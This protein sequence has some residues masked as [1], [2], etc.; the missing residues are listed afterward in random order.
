MGRYHFS[1]HQFYILIL[2]G[3]FSSMSYSQDSYKESPDAKNTVNKNTASH[4][5][6]N[7]VSEE[8]DQKVDSII[9]NGI[10]NHE[11]LRVLYLRQYSTGSLEC[12]L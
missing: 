1:Y 10:K 12:H 2:F 4:L 3:I 5:S 7:L 8:T 6:V 9:S 11:S